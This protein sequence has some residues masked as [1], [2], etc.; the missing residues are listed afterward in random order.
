LSVIEQSLKVTSPPLM[1]TPPPCETQA[2]SHFNGAMERYKSL[3]KATYFLRAQAARSKRGGLSALQRGDGTLQDLKP[4][5][6]LTLSAWL[7]V[8]EQSVKV[9]VPS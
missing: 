6:A 5:A 4:G 1:L 2:Q 8:I 3:I 7:S 9:T